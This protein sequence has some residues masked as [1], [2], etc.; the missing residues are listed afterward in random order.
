M[1][2]EPTYSD[3]V[4]LVR[5]I[6]YSNR[7]D[8]KRSLMT[9]VEELGEM[10]G[11]LDGVPYDASANRLTQVFFELNRRDT[12][13]LGIIETMNEANYNETIDEGQIK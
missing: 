6:M 1:S 13:A 4:D 5:I 10:L 11:E 2:N 12:L 9:M 3:I 7:T 8:D